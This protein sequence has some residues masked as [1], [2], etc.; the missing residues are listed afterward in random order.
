M[1]RGFFIAGW[2]F[3]AVTPVMQAEPK[4]PPKARAAPPPRPKA[5]PKG[6]GKINNPGASVA[7]RLMQM[8]PEQR[9]RALEKFPPEQQARIRQQLEH[10]DTRPEQQRQRVIQE[11]KQYSNLPPESQRL[12]TRQIQFLNHLPDDRGPVVRA[13][14]GRLRRMSDAERQARLN[15]EDFKNKFTPDEQKALAD[16]S[17]NIPLAP[18]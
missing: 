13:E 9:E 18:R 2:V 11:Y 8:T 17:E 7:Q 15:S 16:I 12:V 1:M 5:P 14:L 3:L 10:F 4:V 6:G